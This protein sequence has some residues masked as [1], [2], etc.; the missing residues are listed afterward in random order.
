[1][2]F[3]TASCTLYV[4]VQTGSLR[5]YE[6]PHG[7]GDA[8]QQPEVA[9]WVTEPEGVPRRT[10]GGQRGA[11]VKAQQVETARTCDPRRE[12]ECH[13]P[14]QQPLARGIEAMVSVA[15]YDW[16]S[17]T[18]THNGD[19]PARTAWHEA[20]TQVAEKAK[21]TLP[22]CTGRVEKAV[23]IVLNGDVELL[24]GGK[25]R[26]ASQSNGT[27]QYFV[28][29][30]EC[31]CKDYPKAPHGQCK[32][33]IA[34]GIYVRAMALAKQKLAQLDGRLDLERQCAVVG[35]CGRAVQ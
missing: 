31:A 21:A 17:D 19:N 9:E 30:G 27:T 3:S 28:V 16:E 2:T 14:Q 6:S 23:Q 13:T 8:R 34:R 20:V 33:K 32:H 4:S 15:S 22:E 11:T 25:A 18:W 35:A 29:N 12:A 26:V 5:P 24:E 1:M 10:R 7:A